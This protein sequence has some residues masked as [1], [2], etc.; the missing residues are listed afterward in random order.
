MQEPTKYDSV[1]WIEIKK[2][3]PNPYQ[4]RR[5]FN[6][7][8]LSALAES[9]RQ[10]GVLQPLVVTRVEQTKP[11]GGL[12][13]EYELLAGERRLRASELIGL[14][15]VPAVIRNGKES[16]RAKLEI[17]II[18][19]LQRED[20]NAI[21]RAKALAQLA[22]EF[23]ISH[24]EVGAKIGRSREYVSNSIRLLNLP[25][26]IQRGVVDKEITEGHARALLMLSKR[27]KERDALFRDIML[28]K[29]SVRVTE[30]LARRIAT[31]R[32]RKHDKTPEML[33]L[34]KTLT[35]KLGTR[36]VIEKRPNGGRL[37]IEFFSPD[38]LSHIATLFAEADDSLQSVMP[39][40]GGV[41]VP[42]P[43]A[44]VPASGATFQ[45][46]APASVSPEQSEQIIESEQL[47]GE[48][49]EQ[50]TQHEQSIDDVPPPFVVRNTP[51]SSTE[52][53]TEIP[54]IQT[55][56][57]NPAQ[58]QSPGQPISQPSQ[59]PEQI[60]Q[61][62]IQPQQQPVQP[63]E[64]TQTSQSQVRTAEQERQHSEQQIQSSEFAQPSQEAQRVQSVERE[65]S[66]QQAQ[67]VSQE[68]QTQQSSQSAQVSEQIQPSQP[69]HPAPSAPDAGAP[70]P[71]TPSS[72]QASP[73]TPTATPTPTP[74]REK[75]Q[76]DDLYSIRDFTI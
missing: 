54:V 67:P 22:D 34:E 13:S 11:D 38:D 40:Q 27:P 59:P 28:R 32:V 15:A 36:V 74:Q 10:Y 31:D 35:E 41:S 53:P 76:E 39:A 49:S 46:V 63:L 6:K 56:S 61:Q 66:H 26:E 51:V 12:S 16:A 37:L 24:T 50:S 8:R 19:N 55:V 65:P 21:D 23:G 20:L 42:T 2:I 45:D 30:Q 57:V 62:P 52:I 1:F 3:H 44:D 70:A 25:E 17:A 43:D 29:T 18:E 48:Q 58:S 33:E 47:V 5:D 75:N 9:I 69:Q 7:E 68:P 4:P 72:W 14:H 64:Q 73:A 60:Q 71:A